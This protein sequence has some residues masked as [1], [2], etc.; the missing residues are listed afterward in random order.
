MES[1]ESSLDIF[2]NWHRVCKGL[3]WR[4]IMPKT[5]NR[6][7]YNFTRGCPKSILTAL[8]WSPGVIL[9]VKRRGAIVGDNGRGEIKK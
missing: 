8:E 6:I 1:M 5:R 3:G 2:A 4:F 7:I 9:R